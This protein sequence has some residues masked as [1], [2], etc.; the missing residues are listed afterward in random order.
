M[1]VQDE[2]FSQSGLARQGTRSVTTKMEVRS[3]KKCSI[4]LAIDEPKDNEIHIK[5]LEDYV[6]GESDHEYTGEEDHL[7]TVLKMHNYMCTISASLY[8]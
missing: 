1:Q 2:S 5:G 3:F 8:V 7:L 4:S 6:V